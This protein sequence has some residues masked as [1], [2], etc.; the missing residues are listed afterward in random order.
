M[1]FELH[2]A[3]RLIHQKDSK[4]A[5]R[6]IKIATISITLSIAVMLIAISVLSG[7]K[8]SVKDKI[9][10]FGSH[11]QILPFASNGNFSDTPIHISKQTLQLLSIDKNI[12][13]ITPVIN[14][15]AAI[16]H[17]EDFSA[18]LIKGIT[19]SYDTNFF[20]SALIY[21]HLPKLNKK[22]NQEIL[23]S[24]TIADALKVKLGGKI[25]I[26]FYVNENYRSKKFTISGIYDTG[27][28]DYDE[29]FLIC[30]AKVLQNIFSIDEEYYSCY[31]VS[32]KD[33][34]K[35]QHSGQKLYNS[36]PADLTMQTIT[37]LEPNL[38][39]WLNL[40]DSNVIMIIL[41]MT[42]VTIVTLC[43]V[44]LIMIF[45]KKQLIGILKSFGTPNKSIIKIF[46][47]KA[48]YVTIKGIIYGTIL[49]LSLEIIQKTTNLIKLDPQ[50]YYLTSVPIEIDPLVIII[51][52]VSAL[53]ICTLCMIIPAR[54][55]SKINVVE[56][57][58]FE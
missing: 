34:S 47:Y 50:S 44:I 6:V 35:L 48:A 11:I 26:Y 8:N 9:V 57:M 36:L 39:S 28:G 51:V 10:G 58:K 56:N 54:S 2:F 42:L 43:S 30:D 29:R 5:Q 45:E 17:G 31:E 24:K 15:S 18:V 40:L 53:I 13:S 7:F 38:F 3:K 32:L 25:K 19:S 16:I 21:G 37:E 1:N 41:I 46:L 27:L 20:H 55:I 33:F 12:K 22:E 4:Y 52:D 23:I 49:S 14:K